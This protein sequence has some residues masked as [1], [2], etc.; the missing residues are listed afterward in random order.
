ML[1]LSISVDDPEQ[2]SG[3]HGGCM[4]GFMQPPKHGIIP[5]PKVET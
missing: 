2:A 1:N 4:S 3:R 5:L